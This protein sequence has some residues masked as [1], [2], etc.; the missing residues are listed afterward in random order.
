MF[1]LHAVRR[2][3]QKSD[4]LCRNETGYAGVNVAI[5]LKKQLPL[6]RQL[7]LRR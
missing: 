5:R 6:P 7:R 1:R 3:L 2:L 4:G